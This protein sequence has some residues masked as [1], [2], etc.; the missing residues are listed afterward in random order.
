M[1]KKVPPEGWLR[2]TSVLERS[3]NK[4]WGCHFR[5]PVRVTRQLIEGS[6]R[7]VICTLNSS[8]PYQCAILHRGEVLFLITVNKSLRTKLRLDFG[9]EVEV[10]LKKDK[11]EYGLPLPE[12]L[13][14]LLRQDPEG[15]NL[16]HALTRGKQRTLLYII[17]SAK[18]SLKRV[19]RSIIVV[20]HLKT[21]KGKIN[22]RQLNVAM[23]SMQ[24]NRKSI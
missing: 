15:N 5:V 22:Y 8:A 10:C 23:K 18:S 20:R 17:G 16:F 1:K 7:R 21:N 14:E 4:L 11:S 9:E 3:D 24:S 19:S 6:S 2:F 13:R 12:E